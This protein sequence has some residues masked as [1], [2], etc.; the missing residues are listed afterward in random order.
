MLLHA[1]LK[2]LEA[3]VDQVAVEGGGHGTDGVLQ[4]ADPS[5]Q[6]VV[7]EADGAH[8]DVRMAVEVL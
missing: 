4:E 5:R 7:V 6:V 3:P 2:R 8:D 1:H